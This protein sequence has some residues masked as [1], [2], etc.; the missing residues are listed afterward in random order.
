[1]F[2]FSRNPRSIGHWSPANASEHNE[3]AAIGDWARLKGADAAVW[4]ALKPRFN[5]RQMTPTSAQVIEYL[6]S[7]DEQQKTKAEEYVR[8]APQQI[9]DSLSQGDRVGTGLD[10]VAGQ[11]RISLRYR[12]ESAVLRNTSRGVPWAGASDHTARRGRTLDN[13]CRSCR[14]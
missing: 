9:Q 5:H 8:K 2:C 10:R 4:T 13:G 11:K 7:L 12:T 6:G 1:M 14:Q 3:S